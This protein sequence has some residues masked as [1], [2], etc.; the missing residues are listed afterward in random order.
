MTEAGSFCAYCGAKI[1]QGSKF[2]PNCGRPISLAAAQPVV[3][4]TN[5]GK[6][7]KKR[8][9]KKIAGM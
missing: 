7:L 4:S 5:S 3:G 8:S 6:V 2:C 1:E 9:K